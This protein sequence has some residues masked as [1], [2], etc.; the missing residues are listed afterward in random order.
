MTKLTL[1]ISSPS[2]ASGIVMMRRVRVDLLVYNGKRN[3]MPS[4]RRDVNS[5]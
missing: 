2:R 3:S 5:E 4:L 1:N